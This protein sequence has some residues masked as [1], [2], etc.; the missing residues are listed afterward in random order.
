MREGTAKIHII[1]LVNR[2]Y[3]TPFYAKSEDYLGCCLR[4]DRWIDFSRHAKRT[5]ISPSF[6]KINSSNDRN[7]SEQFVLSS[8]LRNETISLSNK[9]RRIRDPS[10]KDPHWFFFFEGLIE[11][12]IVLYSPAR[13]KSS[14][15]CHTL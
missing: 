9:G 14:A 3:V 5:D 7:E 1:Y 4:A 11:K 13:R 10:I 2:R 15:L 6:G 8:K 12:W